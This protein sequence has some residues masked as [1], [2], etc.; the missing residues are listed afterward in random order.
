MR[1]SSGPGRYEPGL[2]CII[3]RVAGW[4]NLDWTSHIMRDGGL[5]SIRLRISYCG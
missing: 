1:F 2:G 3:V 4:S 5:E